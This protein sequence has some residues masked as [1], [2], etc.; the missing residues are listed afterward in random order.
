M[1]WSSERFRWGPHITKTA[2]SKGRWISEVFSSVWDAEFWSSD[3]IEQAWG[4]RLRETKVEEHWTT[5]VNRGRGLSQMGKLR[6]REERARLDDFKIFYLPVESKALL[7]PVQARK[8]DSRGW[9]TSQ[10]WNS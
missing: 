4:A 9:K 6:P 7:K 2:W 8:P 1:N 3:I 5:R 10:K